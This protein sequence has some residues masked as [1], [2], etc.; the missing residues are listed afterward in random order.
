MLIT[1]TYHDVKTSVGTTMRLLVFHPRIPNYPKAKFPAVVVWSE[2]YQVTG[3]VARFARKI[4][5]RGYIVVCPSSY[6]NFMDHQALPYDG[7]GTDIGNK[8][9]IEK[10]L[11]SYDEDARLAIDYLKT[12]DTCTGKIGTTGMCLGGHLAYRTAFL[13]EVTATVCFFATDIH[14]KTLG[15]NMN[16]D[17]LARCG[18]IKGEVIMIFGTK[19]NHVPPEGRTLI[20]SQ[21]MEKD[22]ALTWLEVNDA[23]HAFIRD[24]SSKGRFDS[25]ITDACMSWLFELFERKLKLDL[26]DND[27]KVLVV[28]DVC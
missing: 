12:L 6:H 27:G 21:M 25:A 16:D 11:E 19:D 18:D 17:S 14:S 7:P 1:D 2:I 15:L 20:R 26:G 23:Q 24:E 4:A 9:K 13:P 5:S 8:Y 28:E 3:P 22:V 10:P